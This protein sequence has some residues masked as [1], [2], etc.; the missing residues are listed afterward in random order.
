MFRRQ[1]LLLVVRTFERPV[2][3]DNT[4]FRGA[5]RVMLLADGLIHDGGVR[6]TLGELD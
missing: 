5:R 4:A 3:L 1:R 6:R 2:E